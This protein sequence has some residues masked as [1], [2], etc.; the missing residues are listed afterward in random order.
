MTSCFCSSS[1]SLVPSQKLSHLEAQGR[2]MGNTDWCVLKP[3]ISSALLNLE[4]GAGSVGGGGKVHKYI[5][6]FTEETSW[7]KLESWT[8]WILS[9]TIII[10][11]SWAPAKLII[12]PMSIAGIDDQVLLFRVQSEHSLPPGRAE[13]SEALDKL[14]SCGEAWFKVKGWH[15]W[16]H[17]VL[18]HVFFYSFV[19]AQD[20]RPWHLCFLK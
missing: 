4:W 12:H 8:W 2:L 7:D 20:W 5:L 11:Y 17:S 6:L 19:I 3:V 16:A 9:I 10:R 15:R 13:T 1:V 14:P 18:L